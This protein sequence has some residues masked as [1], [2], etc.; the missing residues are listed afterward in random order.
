MQMLARLFRSRRATL[1]EAEVY[2]TERAAV[3][4][5]PRAVAI[6]T[7]VLVIQVVVM[8]IMIRSLSTHGWDDGAVTLAYSHTFAETGRIALTA[9]SEQ[10]EGFSSLSWFLINALFATLHPGFE[11]AICAS[12]VLAA[13]C[14]AV[15]T[16]FLFLITQRLNLRENTT[17]A[18]VMVFAVFGPS[19]SEVANGMEM[20]LLT[21]S[22][23]ALVYA[24]Y[25]RPNWTLVTVS[26]TLFLTTRFEAM[27]Y[28][29]VI[30]VPLLPRRRYRGFLLLACLGLVVVGIQ[31]AARWLLFGDILPNTLYAKM[32]TPY[33]K[34]GRSAAIS[35]VFAALEIA[36]V[37]APVIF[38]GVVLAFFKKVRPS[39]PHLAKPGWVSDIIVVAVPI[40]GVEAFSLV[41]GRN[42]GYMGRMQFLAFPF[43]LLL[44][45]ELF[46]H[47]SGALSSRASSV[48]LTVV[49]VGTITLS[50]WL[51]AAVP[52]S[53]S[54]A[55]LTGDGTSFPESFSTTPASFRV[56]GLAVDRLRGLLGMR[57]IVFVTPDVGG[58]GLCCSRIRVVDIGLLTN[59]ELAKRGY[60]ALPDLLAV[61]R[62]DVVEVHQIWAT[63]SRVYSLPLFRLG[64]GAAIVDHTRLYLRRDHVDSLIRQGK[65]TWCSVQENLCAAMALK[66][67]RYVSTSSHV[68]DVEFVASGRFLLVNT[69]GR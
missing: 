42:W 9:A 56:T 6:L 28:Y 25:F 57:T 31:E 64:Y 18:V 5:K 27:I 14:I 16:I 63:S 62:P 20:G 60:S 39:N 55:A 50:W 51:C 45:A 54:F 53:R 43:A 22:G 15:G 26:S 36:I 19:V 8:L 68:D 11:G 44:S 30:L 1:V 59:R 52:M 17:V 34:S 3:G 40:I 46:E 29:A 13:T 33:S 32:H 10:V 49:S 41:T 23:L 21:A 47:F 38:A 4:K 61:E 24:L 65:A 48:I 69:R 7:S 37:M 12:Q 35:R 67:H 58:L 66:T 2:S